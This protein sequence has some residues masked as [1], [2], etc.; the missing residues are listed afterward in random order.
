MTR[1]RGTM[2]DSETDKTIEMNVPNL[3]FR[4]IF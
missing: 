1:V 3:Q 2:M 4:Q